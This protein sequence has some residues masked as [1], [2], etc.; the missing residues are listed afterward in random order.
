MFLLSIFYVMQHFLLIIIIKYFIIY[1]L[2]NKRAYIC[3][4]RN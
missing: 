1:C 4:G 2:F 3:I